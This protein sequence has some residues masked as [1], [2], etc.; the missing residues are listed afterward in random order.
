M[1]FDFII[2]AVFLIILVSIQ[3]TLNKIL[4]ELK[5][6]KN[7]IEIIDYKGEKEQA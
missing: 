1:D 7:K 2:K 3:F 6:I 4:V 5:I